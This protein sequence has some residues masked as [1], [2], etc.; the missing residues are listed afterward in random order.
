M[1][2][3]WYHILQALLLCVIWYPFPLLGSSPCF[4]GLLCKRALTC[5]FFIH[6]WY[7]RHQGHRAGTHW[8]R[9]W[10]GPHEVCPDK[11]RATSWC[12]GK[13]R[14]VRVFGTAPGL[15]WRLK[16]RLWPLVVLI[17]PH[18]LINNPAHLQTWIYT[19]KP[20]WNLI[21]IFNSLLGLAILL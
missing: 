15:G 2:E 18:F 19:S 21:K 10:I 20:A 5:A 9:S 6:Y 14:N 3:S 7:G 4:F 13:G 16:P 17:N 12:D 8:W 11:Q 1:C